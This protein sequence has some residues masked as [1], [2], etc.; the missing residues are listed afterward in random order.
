MQR[1]VGLYVRVSTKGTKQTVDN[2]LRELKG[3]AKRNNWNIVAIHSDQI[4]GAKGRDERPGLDALLKSVARSEIDMVAAWSVDRIGR[5]LI[6]LV[7]FLNELR[8]KRVDLY[9][10]QQGLD[11]TTPAGRALFQVLGIF[12]EFERSIIRERVMA[13]LARAREQGKR[14]GRPRIAPEVEAQIREARKSGTGIRQAARDFGV[15]ISVVQR[16]DRERRKRGPRKA[17]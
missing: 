13:G 14:F 7:S 4:S 16:I 1:R 12:A 5:S 6:D 11:T 15:G 8:S 9:L 3:V 17:V 10:H 2:Q